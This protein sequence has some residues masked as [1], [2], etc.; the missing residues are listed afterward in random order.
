MEYT[1]HN[2]L[3]RFLHC[4]S[5]RCYAK[6]TFE[7]INEWLEYVFNNPNADIYQAKNNTAQ[8]TTNN[9]TTTGFYLIL[10]IISDSSKCFTNLFAYSFTKPGD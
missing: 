2:I 5:R 4:L 10:E 9:I 6:C 3:A 7:S 8:D 1:K